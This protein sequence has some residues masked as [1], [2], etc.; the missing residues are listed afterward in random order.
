LKLT[1]KAED[2]N[3]P[4]LP[5]SIHTESSLKRDDWMLESTFSVAS[6]SKS[7]LPPQEESLMEDYGEAA[8]NSR[9]MSGGVDFFSSLGSEVKKKEPKEKPNP[10]QVSHIMSQHRNPFLTFIYVACNKPVRA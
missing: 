7:Q 9:T 5:S 3:A 10:E 6:T 8:Q 2:P 4:P 1:T